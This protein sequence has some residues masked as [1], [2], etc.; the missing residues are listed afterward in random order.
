M[1]WCGSRR[2]GIVLL[3]V[4]AGG[5]EGGSG[6]GADTDT[7]AGAETGSEA[8][9][10]PGGPTSTTSGSGSVG[11]ED[12]GNHDTTSSDTGDDEIQMVCDRWLT[13]RADMSEGEWS[14]NVAGCDPGDVSAQGRANALRIMNLYRWLADLPP[15]DTSPERDAMAQAC[16]LMMHANGQLSHDPPANWT[17]HSTDGAQGAGNS[18]IAGTAG[19][20]A[21][22][23]YVADP[24]NPD[25]LG[26]RRWILS[27]S[28]GPTGLGSTSEYS[29]MWTLGGSGNAGAPWMA[30]PP[31]G[32][33]PHE[34]MIA[35]WATVDS[36][37]WSLQSDDIDLAGAQV[38]VTRDG[39]VLPVAVHT[40]IGGYGSAYAISFTPQG[41]QTEPG[42]TYRVEVT[43]IA[44]AIDYEVHIV[45]CSGR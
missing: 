16:A 7:D 25:T 10:G 40:L 6:D 3:L 34:A 11:S 4:A 17:C 32:V 28:I 38:E 31:P 5:C 30:F 14:G 44:Q 26:H 19:V 24:G 23:L 39:E 12:T 9:G 27:N 20:R 13:D 15:V 45:D 2:A 8:E 35:S 1:G 43:G 22:D 36:T 42:N 18:N 37:G 33:V 21:V 29:C 41:W